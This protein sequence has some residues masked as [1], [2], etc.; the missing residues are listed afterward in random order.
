[1]IKLF[2]ATIFEN[3]KKQRRTMTTY[4]CHYQPS[5]PTPPLTQNRYTHF[6]SSVKTSKKD[7]NI[8][9]GRKLF[10][11]CYFLEMSG[12]IILHNLVHNYVMMTR[13]DICCINNLCPFLP[14]DVSKHNLIFQIKWLNI[15]KVKLDKISLCDTEC[16][17]GNK[18]IFLHNGIEKRLDSYSII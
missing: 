7:G 5:S 15:G 18:G 9:R 10:F 14:S 2:T 3:L 13:P 1:M 12:F 8:I 6:T 11:K 16:V 4:Y 17:T